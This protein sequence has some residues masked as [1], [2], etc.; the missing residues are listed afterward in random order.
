M[1]TG[2]GQDVADS[3]R[4]RNLERP[5]GVDVKQADA[6]L[7]ILTQ[8][9][10]DFTAA[11][12]GLI[13]SSHRTAYQ[14]AIQMMRSGA[15]SAFSLENEPAE[16]REKYGM[17]QF[18]QGC[19]LARRL[20]EQGVPFCE[21]T[22]S[23]APGTP[24]WD[25]HAD[26]FN[27]VKALSEILDPAWGTLMSDLQDRGLLDST[28]IIWMGE[29]GRTP[30]INGN[31][32]RDHF[33][34]AWTTVLGGGGING[35]QVYGSSTDDGMKVKDSPARVG[36]LIATVCQALGIDPMQQNMSNVG[37]PIRIA[38]PEAQPIESLV[39]SRNS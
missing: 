7:S 12:P 4:V 35:G 39:A 6:R 2:E 29:F 8:L 10:E 25:T 32:G 11:R 16:L 26:N 21:V 28:L 33:P 3:L 36:D 22:L 27:G 31:T 15:S 18:G 37:R 14:R 13:G 20:V 17:N 34:L 30:N 24:G 1:P 5:A 19:L 38:D 23:N 9:E